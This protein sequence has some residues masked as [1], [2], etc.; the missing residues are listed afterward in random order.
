MNIIENAY[1]LV[2]SMK[3]SL[4]RLSKSEGRLSRISSSIVDATV[5]RQCCILERGI[6]GTSSGTHSFAR[7][8]IDRRAAVHL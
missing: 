1:D 6:T 4:S 3:V 8:M 2:G 7:R 5:V